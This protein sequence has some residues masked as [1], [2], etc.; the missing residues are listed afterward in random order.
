MTINPIITNKLLCKT[1][2]QAE[3][4][5]KKGGLYSKQKNYQNST[6]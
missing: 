1:L 4:N 6:I 5:E 2:W 3:V